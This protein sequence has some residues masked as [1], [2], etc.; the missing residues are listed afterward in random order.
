MIIGLFKDAIGW[1]VNLAEVGIVIAAV[2]LIGLLVGR[3]GFWILSRFLRKL[4]GPPALDPYE[5]E[6]EELAGV[7]V[8][9]IR[10]DEDAPPSKLEA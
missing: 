4:G 2:L 3:T 10:P 5:L 6:P 7:K 9:S 1:F 8:V